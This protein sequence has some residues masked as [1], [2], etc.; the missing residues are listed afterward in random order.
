[1]S[2]QLPPILYKK[3]ST[4]LPYN[5]TLALKNR[6]YE[7]QLRRREESPGLQPD[8]LLL[9]EHRPTY[10]SGRRQLARDM[11][12]EE[13]RLKKIGADWEATLRGGETTFHG[14][15]QIVGYP[16]LDLGRSKVS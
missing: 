11:K 12:E 14:P 3:F 15:G 5:Q 9:L 6:I 8:V 2:K 10:T 1:M 16:M 7:L 13:T 4:P